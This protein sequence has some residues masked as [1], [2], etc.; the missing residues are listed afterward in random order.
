M[1]LTSGCI[2]E[3]GAPRCHDAAAL[4]TVLPAYSRKAIFSWAAGVCVCVI[5]WPISPVCRGLG[6]SN[7]TAS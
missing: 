7:L 1:H 2:S 6:L 4:H 3:S 5:S